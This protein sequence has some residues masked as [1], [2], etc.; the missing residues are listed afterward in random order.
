MTWILMSSL[1]FFQLRFWN[2]TDEDLKDRIESIEAK[3]GRSFSLVS[4]T[5]V[6]GD[7]GASII[8][9]YTLQDEKNGT[10]NR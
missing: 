5:P 6:G 10:G 2:H 4:I 7:L 3:T 9:T 1:M 8:V